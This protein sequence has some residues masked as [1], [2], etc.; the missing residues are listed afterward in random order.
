MGARDPRPAVSTVDAVASGRRSELGAFVELAGPISLVVAQ[1]VFSVF[2][3]APEVFLLAG[4]GR[5]T[6]IVFA[7]AL[8]LGPPLVAWLT[9][10]LV[11]RAG[12]PSYRTLAHIGLLAATAGV[13]AVEVAKEA[14][15]PNTARLL[16]L[17]LAVSG[18]VAVALWHHP[19]RVSLARYL[20]F[21]PVLFLVVFLFVSPVSGLIRGDPGEVADVEVGNPVPIVMLVV[22]EL[23]TVSLL[24]GE[25]R[26]DASLFPGF[27]ELAER[28]TW[29]RNHTTVSP[30]TPSALPALVTGNYPESIRPA[31]VSAEF[32]H[33]LFNLLGATYD[34]NV[35][36]TVTRLCAAELCP[37]I[38]QASVA[39]ALRSLLGTANDVF[40][41]IASPG[42]ARESLSFSV[43]AAP[44]DSEAPARFDRFVDSL[45]PSGQ[46]PRLDYA[47]LLLPH[48]P[49]D[50]TPDGRRY[51]APDPPR[52]AEF[53]D[54]FDQPSAD[55]GRQRHLW[56]LQLTDNKLG[57]LLDRLDELGTFDESLLVVT[58]DHGIAFTADAPTRGVAEANYH[59]V[60]WTPLFIKLPGQT[61]GAVRD[62]VVEIID[63]LPTVADIVDVESP[64]ETDGAS[65]VDPDPARVSAPRALDW[66]FNALEPTDGRFVVVDGEEGYDRVLG[67]ATIGVGDASPYR[68]HRVGAFADLVGEPV[69]GFEPGSPITVGLE[70]D[71]PQ[72]T[73][74][75]EGGLVPAYV[76]A[77]WEGPPQGTVAVAVNGIIGA[78]TESYPAGFTH[79]D[80]WAVVPLSLL[81]EGE[82]Q[83][84]AYGVEG[85]PSR[86]VLRALH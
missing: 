4:A 80:F 11:G 82:N 70:Y 14:T 36:E 3:D 83:I 21:A 17:G 78:V 24:D 37:D 16:P 66:D 51:D 33:N 26:V 44:T 43:E 6:I 69:A 84:E 22:D 67:S 5:A 48:Q 50:L 34:L 39:G 31:A 47:H 8:T 10:W 45:G 63:V 68:L 15:S 54:W 62:D 27:A 75:E 18:G 40:G 2:E 72:S 9:E 85:T 56:Q 55:G 58:A 60:L 41:S 42:A 29:F 71:H 73:R 74:L 20:A 35:T 79:S 77:H 12:G 25:G 19:R 23:P 32:P 57:A 61:D 65:V 49:F 52:G 13:A 76:S 38:E 59:E 86:P 46:A 1:P 53:G 28:S 7:L 30:I 64:W 81:R